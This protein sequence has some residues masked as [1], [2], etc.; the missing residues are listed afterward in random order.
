MEW[1]RRARC[2]PDMKAGKTHSYLKNCRNMR[3]GARF[4]LAA[5]GFYRQA[6]I[7]QPEDGIAQMNYALVQQFVFQDYRTAREFYLKALDAAP[8][9]KQIAFNF[10]NDGSGDENNTI[11][12]G[13][14]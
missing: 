10:N 2:A 6:A 8:Y 13:M 9:N 5:V 11:K 7:M 12:G 14:K 1:V 4:D 3:F